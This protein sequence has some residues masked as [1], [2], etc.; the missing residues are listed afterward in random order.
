MPNSYHANYQH[1]IFAVKNHTKVLV[2]MR[3]E[4]H[5][6]ITGIVRGG[7]YPRRLIAIGGPEDHIHLLISAHPAESMADLIRRIKVSSSL[8]INQ[9]PRR[10]GH[11]SWQD[12]Y[13]L[14]SVSPSQVQSVVDYIHNQI[15][16]HRQRTLTEEF[17]LTPTE[18]HLPVL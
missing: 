12:G 11:F 7:K 5:K 13:R 8:F 9:P 4:I 16:H 2:S 17:Y 15:E 18:W 10:Y 3:E 6:Y 14:F 1:I